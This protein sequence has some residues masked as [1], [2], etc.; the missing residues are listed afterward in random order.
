MKKKDELSDPNSCLNRAWG[1]EYIFVLLERD[2][3]A[4][5][6]IREWCAERIRLGKNKPEDEQITSAL[7][8]ADEILKRR[9]SRD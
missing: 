4:P 7:D 9:E 6:M 3:S 5:K 8:M 1:D 2:E